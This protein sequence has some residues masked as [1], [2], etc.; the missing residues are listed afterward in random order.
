M[1]I[2]LGT[3]IV[4]VFSDPMVDAIVNFSS[5]S[6]IPAFYISF[7]VTP[8]ASNSSELVSSF[9]FASKKR[10]KNNSVVYSQVYGA[11][12]MVRRV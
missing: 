10:V 7:V 9:I 8:L 11:V 2:A 4:S 5:A 3:V 6:G 12:T 1:L